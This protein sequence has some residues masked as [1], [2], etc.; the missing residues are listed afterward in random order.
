VHLLGG[1]EGSSIGGDAVTT[2]VV[3][4]SPNEVIYKLGSGRHIEAT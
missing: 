2:E 1:E 4:G 3:V